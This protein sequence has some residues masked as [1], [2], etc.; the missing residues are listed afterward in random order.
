MGLA[1][2]FL[3]NPNV[4][5]LDEPTSNI[6]SLNESLILNSLMKYKGDMAVI[7]ITHKKSSLSIADKVYRL[8]EGE[9]F[10]DRSI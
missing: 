5:L 9:L 1:R 4:L 10:Y 2:V 7:M 8:E 3:R 6:D